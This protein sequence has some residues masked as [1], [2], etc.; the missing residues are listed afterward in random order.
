MKLTPFFASAAAA[1]VAASVSFTAACS[2]DD[3]SSTTPPPSSA[4]DYCSALQSYVSTCK[5][6][7]ACTVAS[8]QTCSQY[9]A[10]FSPAAITAF[11]ACTPALTCGDA[12][13]TATSTCIGAQEAAI[14]PSTAQKKLATDYCTA[15]AAAYAE[16]PIT[17]AQDFYAQLTTANTDEAGSS[18]S[19]S[20]IG[21]AFL[22]L[23]DTLVTS[24]DTACIA[25]IGADAGALAC[26]AGFEECAGT[27]IAKAV[28]TPAA[29][30][31]ETPGASFGFSH[32]SAH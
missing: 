24:V 25:S 22:E 20:D 4:A 14:V 29:C 15:C 28:K 31:A 18:D 17:C 7:D 1:L 12:G 30:Q 11:T 27:I 6:T 5:I 2:S 16:D 26:S 13:A 8:A 10:A 32:L 19:S 21:A 3:S 9:V 23:S